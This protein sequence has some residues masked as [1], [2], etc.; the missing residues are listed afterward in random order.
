MFKTIFYIIFIVVLLYSSTQK[1]LFQQSQENPFTLA[2]IHDTH[3]QALFDSFKHIEAKRIKQKLEIA[4]KAI[5][6]ERLQEETKKKEELQRQLEEVEK[7][8]AYQKEQKRL[9]RI[10]K[11]ELRK[12]AKNKE[13]EYIAQRIIAL[14]KI[15]D[16]KSKRLEKKKKE[17]FIREPSFHSI[18]AHIDLSEQKISVYKGMSLLHEWKVSTARRGYITPVGTYKPLYM[19]KMHYSKKYHNSPMP[20][21]IFFKGGYAIHGTKSIRRLGYI[22]S[23]GCVRLHPKNAKSLYALVKQYGKDNTTITITP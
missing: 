10:K 5:E 17:I 15:E 19:Q 2:S 13:R 18:T 12:A 9:A 23:H 14:Q 21:S 8:L 3:N 22:A 4:Q 1:K 6:K 16:E 11:E 20:Y 7:R